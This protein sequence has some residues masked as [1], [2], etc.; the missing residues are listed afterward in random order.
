MKFISIYESSV[1]DGTFLGVYQ[2]ELGESVVRSIVNA[3]PEQA[4]DFGGGERDV[5]LED[6]VE[7][8]SN[9]AHKL[10]KLAGITRNEAKEVLDI[11]SMER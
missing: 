2:E 4:V 10:A 9:S 6:V 8:C 5:T 3:M 1:V 11:C 7:A